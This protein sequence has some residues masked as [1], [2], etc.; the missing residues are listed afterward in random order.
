MHEFLQP[1]LLPPSLRSDQG[2]DF[3]VAH[4]AA[5]LCGMRRTRPERPFSLASVSWSLGFHVPQQGGKTPTVPLLHGLQARSEMDQPNGQITPRLLRSLPL[6]T[7]GHGLQ[8]ASALSRKLAQTW[9]RKSSLVPA[10]RAPSPHTEATCGPCPSKRPCSSLLSSEHQH[11]ETRMSTRALLTRG[12]G[13]HGT[14]NDPRNHV[15]FD[16]LCVASSSTV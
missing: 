16:H 5:A 10:E 7:Q 12:T 11:A 14:P 8:R 2:L 4:T 9:N 15:S 1:L 13:V 3:Q 6:G